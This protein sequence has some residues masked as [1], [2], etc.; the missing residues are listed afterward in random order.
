M[1]DK[2]TAYY[3]ACYQADFR[4]VN[5]TNFFGNKVLHQHVLH[6]AEILEVALRSYPVDTEWAEKIT[7]HLVVYSK[8][9]TLYCCAFFVHGTARFL[10]KK[11]DVFAPLFLYKAELTWKNNVAFLRIDTEN[12][13][14]NPSIVSLL[15]TTET[16]SQSNI[17]DS[18]SAELPKGI[19]GFTAMAMIE[20]QLQRFFPDLNLDD[21]KGYPNVYDE[22]AVK[23]IRSAAVE[24]GKFKL[25]PA[26]GVGVMKKSMASRGI[27]TELEAMVQANDFSQAIH[28]IFGLQNKTKALKI[29]GEFMIPVTLS[30]S[31]Q[32]VF[33]SV[34]KNELTLVVGPPGTGKSFTIAALAVEML[35][36]GMSVLIASKNDQA[37]NVIANKIERDFELEKVVVNAANKD[38]KK[39]LQARLKNLLSGMT[40]E[41]N[42][43]NIRT[44][45]E[46]LRN[47][48]KDLDAL[49]KTAELRA[50][51]ERE[52]GRNLYDDQH[53][54]LQLN[55]RARRFAGFLNM[56]NARFFEK[57]FP[58][59]TIQK[60]LA[61][62]PPLWELMF[63][64]EQLVI[65][66]QELTQRLVKESFAYYLNEGLGKYRSEVQKLLKAIRARTGNKKEGI[67]SDIDF[68][69]ILDTF[70]VWTV[71]TSE[72]HTVLPLQKEVFDLVIIDEATQCD[73]ASILPLLQRAKRAV[74]VGDP[75]QLRHL[76]FLSRQQQA[77]LCTQYNLQDIDNELLNYREKSVL[78]LV[79]DTIP[80]QEQVQFLNEHYRSMP[81]IIH[82]SNERFYDNHLTIMT[83]TPATQSHQH[84]FLHPTDGKRYKT[85]YNKIE[86]EAI[87]DEVERMMTEEKFIHDS[88]CQ[89]IG[90]LSPFRE[91]VNYLQKQISKRFSTQQLERHR[92]LVG[93]PFNFQGEERD[94]MLLSFVLDNAAH[95]SAFQ[96]LNRAD[97]FNVSIT[98]ARVL[99]RVYTSFDPA[100][101]NFQNLVFDYVNS[102]R[103]SNSTTTLTPDAPPNDFMMEVADTLLDF[104]VRQL[105]RAYP[106]A[107]VEIDIVV[108]NQT[109]QTCCIDLVG[110]PGEY[111]D[112]LPLERWR[113]LE[114][115]GMRVFFLSYSRWYFE[116]ERCV[117]AL[118][119][120]VG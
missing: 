98:R 17:Y 111:E 65:K 79:F 104:D 50:K 54:L 2:I 76:S 117:G 94:V 13:L 12:T 100:Q 4:T 19:I 1:L 102:L 120:F 71:N 29:K 7:Q 101:F 85:G 41:S 6:S 44:L 77:L 47:L 5:L 58:I 60:R 22:A 37:V 97:V 75:K 21:L 18:L 106:I 61:N 109:G 32:A 55:E 114:R 112:V 73:T 88:L 57:H 35:T 83:A 86:A 110:Y 31:Q 80:N 28:S 51:M 89:S 27:L 20:E 52:E 45:Q 95:S 56:E 113:M 72:V 70:P 67:F 26:I 40:T 118:R 30:E 64:I 46:K 119:A 107:G 3:R 9:Q 10:G 36:R 90:I 33:R 91:Q 59:K 14:L 49:E 78:D 25:I 81:D 96:Y 115:V 108:V 62:R 39:A 68:R 42:L 66:R 69:K 105:Y 53:G 103:Q 15:R 24:E 43:Y 38:Y 99:Q 48:L 11:Q 34:F 92:I 8:E 82:F 23:A 87:L 63:N 84:I 116:R 16:D 74:I 93:T